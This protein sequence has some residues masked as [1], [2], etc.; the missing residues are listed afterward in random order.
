M[1]DQRPKKKYTGVIWIGE[2]PGQRFELWA[3]SS[4]EAVELVKA[5]HGEGHQFT[6]GNEEDENRLRASS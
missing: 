1:P 2:A 4:R 5:K 3:T 6:V